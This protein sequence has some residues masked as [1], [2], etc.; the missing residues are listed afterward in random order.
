MVS[1]I[2]LQSGTRSTRGSSNKETL[3]G[4]FILIALAG[5]AAAVLVKQSVYDRSNFFGTVKQKGTTYAPKEQ[6]TRSPL[7]GLS[8]AGFQPMNDTEIFDSE[9]LSQKINGKAELYLEAGFEELHCRRFVNND[10]PSNWF[11]LFVYQMKSAES[12]F[13]VY[14]LQRRSEAEYPWNTSLAYTTGNALFFTRGDQYI[15]MV[16][17]S[18]AEKIMNA[19]KDTASKIIPEFPELRFSIAEMK[20]LPREGLIAGSEKLYQENAFGFSELNQILA[21]KYKID[22]KEITCFVSVRKS[23]EA[24]SELAATYRDSLLNLGAEEKDIQAEEIPGMTVIDVIGD[25]EF[26]ASIDDVL[27]G[28]HATM[29]EEAGMELMK[30][31]AMNIRKRPDNDGE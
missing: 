23:P 28:V 18:P 9:T 30:R 26:F 24:A 3:I 10:D 17:A 25:L 29:H 12:A 4:V 1:G 16:A 5:V 11:E 6:K 27:F 22:E 7:Q 20:M 31:L 13:S 15:E 19:M 8:P 2:K 21:A 14:S